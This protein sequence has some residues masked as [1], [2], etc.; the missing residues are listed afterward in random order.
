[1]EESIAGG[2]LGRVNGISRNPSLSIGGSTFIVNNRPQ[3]GSLQR[4]SRPPLERNS[5]AGRTTIMNEK[6]FANLQAQITLLSE[7]LLGMEELVIHVLDK[8]AA[9]RD[10]LRWRQPITPQA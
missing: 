5:A 1:M 3:L 9:K 7:Q 8:K 4:I 6:K 2:S 10:P